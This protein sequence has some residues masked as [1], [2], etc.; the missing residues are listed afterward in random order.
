MTARFGLRLLAL[1]LPVA[2]LAPA[3]AHA[4]SLTVVDSSGDA[5]AINMA[6]AFGE[7]LD[8]TGED[9]PFFLDAPNETSA[10]VVHTTIDHARKRLTL[11]AA[12]P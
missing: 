3:A 12:V 7:L 11:S 1:A 5:Q 4:R 9:G 10:D 8:G 2:L 6:L